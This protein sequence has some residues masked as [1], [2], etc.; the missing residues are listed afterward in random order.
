VQI[1]FI[2]VPR[3]EITGYYQYVGTRQTITELKTQLFDNWPD[4]CRKPENAAAMR[5]I[6]GGELNFAVTCLLARARFKCANL[7]CIRMQLCR[8]RRTQTRRTSCF[9]EK[10]A[11]RSLFSA[12]TIATHYS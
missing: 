9:R 3:P 4:T 12:S 6:G 5:L 7:V 2:F 11:G 1:R 10:D 8:R